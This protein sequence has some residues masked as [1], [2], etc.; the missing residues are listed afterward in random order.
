MGYTETEDVACS[1]R[2]DLSTEQKGVLIMKGVMAGELDAQSGY[3]KSIQ[4]LKDLG[5]DQYANII[6]DFILV[7]EIEHQSIL[8]TLIKKLSPE[9]AEH[10]A[11]GEETAESGKESD[12]ASDESKE[13]SVDSDQSS[14]PSE[15]EEHHEEH[16]ED[17]H[18]DHDEDHDDDDWHKRVVAI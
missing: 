11:A 3:T 12:E 16:H 9:D 6:H 8:N 4:E 10:A 7:D 17:H 1:A 13:E 15:P 14:E 5:L 18:G 2:E